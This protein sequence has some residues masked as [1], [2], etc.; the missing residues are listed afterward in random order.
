MFEDNETA[1]Q[2][3]ALKSGQWV[4][5]ATGREIGRTQAVTDIGI[6]VDTHSDVETLSLRRAPQRKSRGGIS[7]MAV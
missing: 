4:C 7:P 6:E 2:D 1:S 3:L 5:D